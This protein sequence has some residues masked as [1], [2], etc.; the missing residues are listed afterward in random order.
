[1]I[2]C[3]IAFSAIATVSIPLHRKELTIDDFDFDKTL[4]HELDSSFLGE[5]DIEEDFPLKDYKMTQ[6]FMDITIGTPP[7]TFSVIPDTGSSNLWVYSSKCWASV[8]CWLHKTY[9]AKDSA[10]SIINGTKFEIRYGSGRVS[11]HL[12]VDYSGIG[13]LTTRNFTFAEVTS[14][15]GIAFWF[16]KFDG[17]LGLGFQN[18]SVMHLPLWFESLVNENHLNKSFSIYLSPEGGEITFGGV[19]KRKFEGELK[20]FKVIEQN[21]WMVNLTHAATDNQQVSL[22]G[23]NVKGIIDSGTSLTIVPKWLFKELF[24]SIVVNQ[25]CTGINLLPNVSFSIEGH[26]FELIPQE[27]IISINVYGQQA[28]ILGIRG[29]EFGKMPYELIILGDN[30]M[31][32]YYT[33]FDFEKKHIGLA[34]A[35]QTPTKE[36]NIINNEQIMREVIV[37]HEEKVEEVKNGRPEG[38]TVY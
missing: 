36:S 16:G 23:R 15:S 14:S 10:T 32:A 13:N 28:C 22:S 25:D 35:K 31:R 30:F 2:F 27:Y 21:Y 5:E 4:L 18:I 19:D 34:R 7:Q 17:I 37:R 24:E 3:C 26:K 20:Y 29:M 12:S 38:F 1:V 33:H 6:Y 9:N 8:A 11:G